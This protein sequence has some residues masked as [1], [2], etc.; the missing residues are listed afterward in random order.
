MTSPNDV[1][2]KRICWAYTRPSLNS[3]GG[4]NRYHA[5]E[6]YRYIYIS[7]VNPVYAQSC[8]HKM[9]V[10][11]YYVFIDFFTQLSQNPKSVHQ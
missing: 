9:I 10:Y 4:G 1:L 7:T 11:I 8:I 3:T 5:T 2:V 6:T